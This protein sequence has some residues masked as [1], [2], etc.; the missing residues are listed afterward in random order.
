[1]GRRRPSGARRGDSRGGSACA[2]YD[3]AAHPIQGRVD[4]EQRRKNRTNARVRSKVEWPFRI[5]KRV[6]GF[7]KSALSRPEEE[8][9]MAAGGLRAG[10]SVPAP[11]TADPA[12][13][14]VCP[15]AG[16]RPSDTNIST[17]SRKNPLR[18]LP[19]KYRCNQSPRISYLC[20]ASLGK[21]ETSFIYVL[22]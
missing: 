21:R 3:L 4:E 8:S 18:K 19:E 10:E 11:Q 12:R 13:G 14:V 22:G 16:K 2:G 20:R 6:F 15:G 17:Q 1:M 5:L 7:T 9:R